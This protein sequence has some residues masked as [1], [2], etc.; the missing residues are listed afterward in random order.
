[1]LK[2][3]NT[4]D[5]I[6]LSQLTA[7]SV[8]KGKEVLLGDAQEGKDRNIREFDERVWKTPNRGSN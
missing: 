8:E 7:K 3:K 1:M 5:E 2:R 4:E 6:N